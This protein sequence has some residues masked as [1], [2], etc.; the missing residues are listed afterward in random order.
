VLVI[1]A[2]IIE[3]T[4]ESTIASSLRPASGNSER[5]APAAIAEVIAR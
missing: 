4:I 2:A 1:K 5:S 3:S